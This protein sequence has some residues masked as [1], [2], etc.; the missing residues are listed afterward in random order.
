MIKIVPSEPLDYG[1]CQN[2]PASDIELALPGSKRWGKM[3]LWAGLWVRIS[4]CTPLVLTVC[5]SLL[6]RVALLDTTVCL[7]AGVPYSIDVTLRKLS[8]PNTQSNQYILIDSVSF[9]TA[10]CK[11]VRLAFCSSVNL[12]VCQ[13]RWKRSAEKCAWGPEMCFLKVL[14]YILSVLFWNYL[15]Q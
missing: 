15:M 13:P 11:L 10:L 6:C 5:L 1:R 12:E 2:D 9:L 3:I 7:E 8:S 14:L 4:N